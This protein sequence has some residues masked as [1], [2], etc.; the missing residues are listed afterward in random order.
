MHLAI[1]ENRTLL[2]YVN[3]TRLQKFLGWML[4]KQYACLL[5]TKVH[6]IITLDPTLSFFVLIIGID[7]MK[8]KFWKIAI[9]L[10]GSCTA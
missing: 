1:F 10:K 8:Y 6:I 5:K 3:S 4:I 9:Y 7:F 2:C